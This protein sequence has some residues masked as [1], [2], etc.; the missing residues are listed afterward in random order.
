MHDSQIVVPDSFI[1][2]FFR[3]GRLRPDASPEHIAHRHE[4]CD[5]MAAML[6]EEAKNVQWR[7]GITEA[8]VLDKISDGLASGTV[9]LTELETRWV[10]CR[11]AELLEWTDFLASPQRP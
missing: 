7:L 2:L 3:S 4:I 8:D 5:D 1:K 6:C 9:P 10:I 11:L